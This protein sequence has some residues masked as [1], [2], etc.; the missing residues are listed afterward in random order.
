ML[1]G[2]S[3]YMFSE[4]YQL[5]TREIFQET[6]IRAPRLLLCLRL[7][8]FQLKTGSTRCIMSH[9]IPKPNASDYA[10][11]QLIHPH[12]CLIIMLMKRKSV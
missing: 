3:D 7:Y 6:G 2:R 11:H 9:I 8:Q 12:F 10:K 4:I 5:L 1:F